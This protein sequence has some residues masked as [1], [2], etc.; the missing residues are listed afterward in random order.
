MVSD[1]SGGHARR[2][3][4][5]QDQMTGNHCWGCGADN[6]E[7]L[8]LKSFWDGERAHDDERR[9]IGSAPEIW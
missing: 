5:I 7:G 3:V 4:A 2:D 9:P 6:P 8:Q 1:M